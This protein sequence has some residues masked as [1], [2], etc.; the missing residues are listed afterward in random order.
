M[1]SYPFNQQDPL[2]SLA[3]NTGNP[4]WASLANP[5]AFLPNLEK[6]KSQSPTG[7]Y[8]THKPRQV[9]STVEANPPATQ[10]PPTDPTSPTGPAVATSRTTPVQDVRSTNRTSFDAQRAANN[11]SYDSE[12]KGFD[13]RIR[14]GGSVTPLER[15]RALERHTN[16]LNQINAIESMN[17]KNEASKKRTVERRNARAETNRQLGRVLDESTASLTAAFDK[18]NAT[19]PAE[20]VKMA[21]QSPEDKVQ[22]ILD[23]RKIDEARNRTESMS[24]VPSRLMADQKDWLDHAIE[25]TVKALQDRVK[26]TP[27]GQIAAITEPTAAPTAPAPVPGGRFG[28]APAYEPRQPAV[29][30]NASNQHTYDYTNRVNRELDAIRAGQRSPFGSDGPSL[31]NPLA[32]AAVPAMDPRTAQATKIVSDRYRQNGVDPM[33]PAVFDRYSQDVDRE[34][35]NMA[36]GGQVGEQPV[37][38]EGEGPGVGQTILQT[39][40]GPGGLIGPAYPADLAE[41]SIAMAPTKADRANVEGVVTMAQMQDPF[42]TLVGGGLIPEIRG[43][44]VPE[45]PAPTTRVIDNPMV[46]GASRPILRGPGVLA[47][48]PASPQAGRMMDVTPG[49]VGKPVTIVPGRTGQIVDMPAPQA[50]PGVTPRDLPTSGGGPR[51]GPMQPIAPAGTADEG[52]TAPTRKVKNV[53]GPIK[54]PSGQRRTEANGAI[55]TSPTGKEQGPATAAAQSN[56]RV[57]ELRAQ[58]RVTDIINNLVDIGVLPR[59]AASEQ[60]VP[61]P[62]AQPTPQPETPATQAL[63]EI[64]KPP[65]PAPVETKTTTV[66]ANTLQAPGLT[67]GQKQ[68]AVKALEE[69]MASGKITKQEFDLAVNRMNNLGLSPIPVTPEPIASAP[70][71][72]PAQAAKQS[73]AKQLGNY[74]KKVIDET[75]ALLKK[76]AKGEVTDADVLA[77]LKSLVPGKAGTANPQ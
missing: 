66:Q 35:R 5:F 1:P 43:G 10:V 30:P 57:R 46:Q 52:F 6:L 48:S 34:L 61:T 29:N 32:G 33:D 3:S 69:Q 45:M 51:Q 24:P 11:A 55:L 71:T 14:Q 26:S 17:A 68:A 70:A 59:K 72:A 25:S 7:I 41:R 60:P 28:N 4:Y 19:K 53:P 77:Y 40:A 73:V 36:P 16:R 76:D 47:V 21:I 50:I 54:N 9:A 64:A 15:K 39:L 49:K 74:T 20:P 18:A 75:R 62:E 67:P 13:E 63:N 8:P 22:S 65:A 42:L 2:G 44:A 56:A 27:T 58:D 23:M 12:L 31:A 38:P 37:L